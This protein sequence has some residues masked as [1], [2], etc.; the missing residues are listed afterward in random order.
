MPGIGSVVIA[1]AGTSDNF[2]NG[3]VRLADHESV[4]SKSE[5]ESTKAMPEI[6]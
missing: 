2:S 4:N 3:D 5:H 1:F 6:S